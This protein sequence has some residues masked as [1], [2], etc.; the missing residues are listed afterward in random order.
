MDVDCPIACISRDLICESPSDFLE[1]HS[2]F[3]ITVI[4]IASGG[5]GIVLT[6]FLKSR[7]TEI[8]CGCLSCRRNPIPLD[9]DEVA[10]TVEP[11]VN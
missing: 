6:Y 9:I 1:K 10:V 3:L 8:K 4:G 11:D 7:C 5:L 2:S